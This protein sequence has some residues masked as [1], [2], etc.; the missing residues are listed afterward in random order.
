MPGPMNEETRRRLHSLTGVLPLL[1]YVVFHVGETAVAPAG[2]RHFADSVTGVGGGPL[3]VTL[4]TLVI[5]VPLLL[6]AVLGV[7]V[8]LR[9]RHPLPQGYPSEGLR[10]LQRLTGIIVL[11]FLVAH[12]G[13]T[14]TAKL[15]GLDGGALY[16][17][18]MG[19]VGRPV[20]LVTYAVGITAVALHIA[21]GIGSFAATWGLARTA[22]G[23]RA[24]RG[25]GALIA[26]SV[27]LVSLNTLSHFAVG[28]AVFGTEGAEV[29]QAPRE[30]P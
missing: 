18:L 29:E 28:R 21:Q 9:D 16:D 17:R 26:L 25:V 8:T 23:R 24:A 7:H 20:F 30:A 11:L 10:K 22:G 13:H 12:V 3:A 5:L 15:A 27:W 19:S 1:G 4:E 2:R 14:W 6:H